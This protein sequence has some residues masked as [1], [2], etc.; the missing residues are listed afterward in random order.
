MQMVQ[1]VVLDQQI[2][3]GGS[4]ERDSYCIWRISRSILG[5]RMTNLHYFY[6]KPSVMSFSKSTWYCYGDCDGV[7]VY[8]NLH[9]AQTATLRQD[10]LLNFQEVCE[11]RV[12]HVVMKP[13][14]KN[15][16]N[17]RHVIQTES[18]ASECSNTEERQV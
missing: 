13:S 6:W 10:N 5:L 18:V 16:E 8:S 17:L 3:Q 7:T 12:G 1:K 15:Y 2:I 9:H 11:L 4:Q 14:R